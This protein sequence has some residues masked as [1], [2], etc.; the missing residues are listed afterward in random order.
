[1]NNNCE[2]VGYC[3][4]IL[5][6]YAF[7]LSVRVSLTTCPCS[8]AVAWVGNDDDFLL[9]A[10][11]DAN[12]HLKQKLRHICLQ[13]WGALLQW[14]KNGFNGLFHVHTDNCSTVI[15]H[16]ALEHSV[17]T[18][19]RQFLPSV[20]NSYV[21]SML[22][23]NLSWF[24]SL[25]INQLMCFMFHYLLFANDFQHRGGSTS[26]QYHAKPALLYP[27]SGGSV[28]GDEPVSEQHESSSSNKQCCNKGTLRWEGQRCLSALV[29]LIILNRLITP[30]FVVAV[31]CFAFTTNLSINITSSLFFSL[32]W[33]SFIASQ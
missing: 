9:E 23:T 11:N 32:F 25:R 24:F 4:K 33:Q 5:C 15:P 1:M 22:W 7:I 28:V 18:T 27:W 29:C 20:C 31:N 19:F 16:L 6:N 14:L 2:N 30:H 13:W 10:H 26:V 8:Y 21:S 12:Q 3:I 17:D